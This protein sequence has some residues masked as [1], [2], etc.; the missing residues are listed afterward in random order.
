MRAR[1]K[2][3]FIFT[4]GCLGLMVLA[5]LPAASAGAAAQPAQASSSSGDW[6]AWTG[7]LSGDRFA[8]QTPV[9]PANVSGLTVK[10]AFTEPRVQGAFQ[11]SQP[12]V[13]GNTLYVGSTDAKF[14]ALNA[15]TGATLWTFDL[16]S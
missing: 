8:P 3:W 2:S 13:V 15:K 1:N 6:P 12:A 14:Y 9:K 4:L 5:T 10:W 11:S 7:G 16:T